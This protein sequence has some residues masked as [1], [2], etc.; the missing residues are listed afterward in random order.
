[1][2]VVLV[3]LVILLLLL[4]V[5][6]VVVVVVALAV[7]AVPP[8]QGTPCSPAIIRYCSWMNG[9]RLVSRN[10]IYAPRTLVHRIVPS[11]SGRSDS[12]ST[13]MPS[14]PCTFWNRTFGGP[15]CDVM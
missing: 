6:V 9:S 14:Q 12:K 10:D 11:I 4:V 2:A 13:R 15:M 1:M 3:L 7:G 5:V 8:L